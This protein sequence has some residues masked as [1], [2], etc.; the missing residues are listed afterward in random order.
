M[1]PYAGKKFISSDTDV[2]G[3]VRFARPAAVGNLP[4]KGGDIHSTCR[5]TAKK[6]AARTIYKKLF[7]AELKRDMEKRL[8][9]DW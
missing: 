3:N 2:G 8:R 5:N 9:E 4:G 6:Q 1:S 7:R